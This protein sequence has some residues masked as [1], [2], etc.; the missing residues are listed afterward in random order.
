[1]P[2]LAG[3]HRRGCPRRPPDASA[4]PA[5]GRLAGLL[6]DGEALAEDHRDAS[7]V[8]VPPLEAGVLDI[9]PFV[10]VIITLPARLEGLSDVVDAAALEA[11]HVSRAEADDVRGPVVLQG[12]A[13]ADRRRRGRRRPVGLRPRR[14]GAARRRAGRPCP[15]CERDIHVRPPTDDGRV[16]ITHEDPSLFM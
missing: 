13:P 12:D 4:P 6:A 8:T 11:S 5:G 7:R 10:L 2:A 1:M 14:R 9:T 15:D 3:A 16:T